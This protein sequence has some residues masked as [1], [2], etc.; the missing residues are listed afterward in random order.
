MT[1]HDV[2]SGT[3]T[4]DVTTNY[5]YPT[6]GSPQPHTLT[7]TTATNQTGTSTYSYDTAGNTLARP[8]GAHGETMTWN[9]EGRLQA[10][11]NNGANSAY[12]YDP[13]G[14]QLI[15]RDTTTGSTAGTTTLYLG[16]LE[17]HLNTATN[18]VTGNRYYSYTGAPTITADQA[19]NLTYEIANNQ[20]TAD[21]T[22]NAA[23]GKI[24]ARRY[25]TPYGTTRGTPAPTWPDDHTFLGKTTDTTTGLIDVG[26]RKYD[27]TTGRFIST[28][29]VFEANDPQQIGGYAYA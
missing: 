8:S 14:N 29:P 10:V 26:A 7:S 1:E 4:G 15:R 12:L 23:T 2:T 21:T 27:P 16:A 18:T 19:G 11:S 3:G 24:T 20:G 25:N 28:D 13:A 9:A 5:N 22:I 6:A 17:L